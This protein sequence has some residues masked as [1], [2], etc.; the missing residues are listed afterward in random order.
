[1]LLL[2]QAACCCPFCCLSCQ[3]VAAMLAVALHVVVP[4][5]LPECHVVCFV[6]PPCIMQDV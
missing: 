5:L 1:M 4:S 2:I 3:K 6:L